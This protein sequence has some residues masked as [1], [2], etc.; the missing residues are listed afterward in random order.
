MSKPRKNKPRLHLVKG[1]R[2]PEL[3]HADLDWFYGCFDSEC[4]LR[5]IGAMQERIAQEGTRSGPSGRVNVSRDS[6]PYSGHHV[7]FG[8]REGVF[9]K[10]R[11]IWRR[12]VSCP[13]W[14]QDVLKRYYEPRREGHG[15][16]DG[17]VRAAHRAYCGLGATA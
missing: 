16:N 6:I 1:G 13:L 2:D 11:R 17:V 3:F 4:G 12:L 5:G 9:S 8:A 15:L 7:D 10:G 14:A